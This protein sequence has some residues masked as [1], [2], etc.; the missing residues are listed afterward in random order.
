MSKAESATPR[1]LLTLAAGMLI[2]GVLGSIHAFSVFVVPLEELLSAP[3]AQISSIYS[4][5]L[6]CLTIAVLIGHALYRRLPPILL[7]AG[8]CLAAAAGLVICSQATGLGALWIGYSV[9][10][11]TANG[12]GYGYTLQ[13]VAQAWPQ[14]KGLAMGAVTAFYALGATLFAKILSML[15]MRYGI[16]TAYLSMAGVLLGVAV[17]VAIMLHIARASYRG[18]RDDS[19]AASGRDGRLLAY[20]WLGY[21]LGVVAGL[22]AIGHAAGLVVARGGVGNL[23]VLGAM[24]I[25]LGN[26]AGGF[27]FG[28][29]ADRWPVKRL[30]GLLPMLSAV[31]LGLLISTDDAVSTTIWLCAVGFAYG[32]VIAVYPYTAPHYFGAQRAAQFYGIVF[33]AWG[34]AGLV[35]PWL[36]GRLFDMSGNYNTALLVACAAAVASAL[37]SRLLPNEV[38]S[39]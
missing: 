35:G 34:L 7:A 9:V 17:A 22:M 11:G 16:G 36:A 1:P 15:I 23:P 19:A 25:G 27:L 24:L 29:L 21:G 6:V 5:A 28:W 14:R 26:A 32:A 39:S 3:R 18:D 2:T 8:A 38:A 13:L 33:T 30:L 12:V 4:L 20:L 10:F 37:V 31:A